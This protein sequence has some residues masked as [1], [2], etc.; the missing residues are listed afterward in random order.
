MN[1]TMLHEGTPAQRA[2]AQVL[3]SRSHKWA[4]G[5]DK[6]TG[7]QFVTFASS[8]MGKD[9]RPVFYRTRID[10][11]GCTCEGARRYPI[12]SHQLACRLDADRAR[13]AAAR[14]PVSRYALLAGCSARNCDN[15][16]ESGERFCST[17]ATVSAF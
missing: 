7:I 2:Q 9:G 6:Q 16:R 5:Y 14:K 13:E 17:H 3:L 11:Q 1:S 10:G 12:C 8:R 15:D 4:R